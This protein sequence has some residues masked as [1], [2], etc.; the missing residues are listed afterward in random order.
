MQINKT[1]P[2]GG[3][4]TRDPPWEKKKSLE[5]RLSGRNEKKQKKKKKTKRRLRMRQRKRPGPSKVRAHVGRKTYLQAGTSPE[6]RKSQ[7]EKTA[8]LKKRSLPRKKVEGL[9]CRHRKLKKTQTS[10]PG[11][12]V[13]KEWKQRKVNITRGE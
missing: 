8:D 1:K 13:T 9:D 7:P 5:R 2:K 10:S 6:K 11:G 3:R 12:E 4:G